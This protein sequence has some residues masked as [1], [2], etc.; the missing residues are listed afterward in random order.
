MS[1]TPTKEQFQFFEERVQYFQHVLNLNDWRIEVSSKISKRKVY[2]EV[3]I[4]LEDRLAIVKIGSGW[5]KEITNQS[6]SDL[7]LHEVLHV[8]L[9]TY[10]SACV[11]RRGDWIASEEHALVVLLEKLLHEDLS[12]T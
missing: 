11:S 2:A 4:S 9:K 10:Q 7:A 1:I 5:D 6:L 8:F 12:S 3:G